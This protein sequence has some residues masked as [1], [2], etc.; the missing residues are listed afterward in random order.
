[1]KI[2][3][4]L[5]N[6][7]NDLLN[8]AMGFANE[9]DFENAKAM[10]EEAEKVEID[11]QNA[12]TEMENIRAMQDNHTITNIQ[13]KGVNI[14]GATVIDST[15]NLNND[16]DMY[17]SIEYRKAF[18]NYVLKGKSMPEK[19]ANNAVTKTTDVGEMIPS[20]VMEKIVEK[21]E[22]TGMILPLVTRTSYKG[23][24]S[25]P[26]SSVKPVASWV[27]QGGTSP[28]QNKTLDGSITFAY[29]KLRCAVAV[30][31]ETD[32]MALSI[33]E[34]TLINNVAEAM[35][36]AIEE[37]I[38]NG[39]GEGQPK[40][41]LTETAP[42]G[43]TLQISNI[44]Y[45]TL[46]EAESALPLEYEE[47]AIYCMTK[48][49]FMAYLG[50]VDAN[51]QPIAR[52]TYGIGGKPERTLLGRTVKLCN[53][54]DSYSA[55]LEAGKTFAFLF[56]FKDYVLNTNLNMGIKTYEDNE[57]DD[58]IKKS[59]MLVDGKVVEKNSLVVLKKK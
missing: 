59:I 32:T 15:N 4:Q 52:V 49:T 8:K 39:T 40:G 10:R 56:D 25:I 44:G 37:S 38:I 29:H 41:I 16:E 54:I 34:K 14:S 19:F 18:M 12:I 47:G 3:E 43:Q 57:T 17:A 9:G 27:A 5:R 20:T 2:I 1:M 22:A 33:F 23:G 24:V 51:G 26:T 42:E 58:I 28:K 7:K 31:L 53:Y 46:I 6:K 45:D 11:L 13:N 30:T 50:M 35:V 48:K 21:I 55:T 36:K